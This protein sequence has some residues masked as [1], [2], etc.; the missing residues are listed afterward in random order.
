MNEMT[1]I[2]MFQMLSVGRKSVNVTYAWLLSGTRGITI[3]FHM[4]NMTIRVIHLLSAVHLYN[5]SF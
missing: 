1:L 3:I 5:V 4:Y 2:T